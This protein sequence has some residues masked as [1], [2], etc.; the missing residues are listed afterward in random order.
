MAGRLCI[1]VASALVRLGMLARQ[2]S[3]IHFV[4]LGTTDAVEEPL[5]W[6]VL[7]LLAEVCL[8]AGTAAEVRRRSGRSP[9]ALNI[10]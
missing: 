3:T 10:W 2:F 1:R 8:I 7:A 6:A 9:M 4:G 5:G